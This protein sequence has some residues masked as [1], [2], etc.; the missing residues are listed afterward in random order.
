M[1]H[2][3]SYKMSFFVIR[4]FYDIDCNSEYF[5][6]AVEITI[7]VAVLYESIL[8]NVHLRR[9]IK[10]AGRFSGIGWSNFNSAYCAIHSTEFECIV[11]VVVVIVVN[12]GAAATTAIWPK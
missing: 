5:F 2:I 4:H 1:Q 6:V 9:Y 7:L 8:E 11:I 3:K 10:I 12:N